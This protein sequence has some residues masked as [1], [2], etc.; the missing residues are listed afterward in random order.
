MSKLFEDSF[1]AAVAA[2]A[3]LNVLPPHLPRP[4][5]GRTLV[6]ATGKAAASMAVAVERYWPAAVP[7]EGIAVTRYGHSLPTKR[8]RVVEA[9][10][11]V[12]DE[13]GAKSGA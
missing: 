8:I 9:G 4:P 13:A 5:R 11:P 6:A 7:L 3:P 1:R 2:A 10:H 12:A